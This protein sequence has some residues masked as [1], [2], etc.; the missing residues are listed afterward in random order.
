[1]TPPIVEVF[2]RDFRQ[3][4]LFGKWTKVI[5][6]RTKKRERRQ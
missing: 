5:R 3:E 1:M 4:R 6:H 2:K